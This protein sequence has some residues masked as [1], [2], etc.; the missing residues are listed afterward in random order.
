MYIKDIF[1]KNETVISLEVFPPKAQV[2]LEDVLPAVQTLAETKPAYMSVTYG[3]GGG[4]TANALEVAS[5][6]QNDFGV[7]ALAHLTCIGATRDAILEILDNFKARNIRNILALR[8]DFP[9]EVPFDKDSMEYKYAYQL[10][11]E[12][13]AYG[14]F[15]VGG[16]CYPEGHVENPNKEKDID[17]L[18]YKIEAG[19][20]FLVT[21]LF[22]DNNMLYSFLYRL[23]A[24]NINIPVTAGI[25]PVTSGNSIKRMC[26]MSGATLTPKFRAMVDKFGDKPDALRQAGIA[27]ATEQIIDLISNGV[28]RIHIYTMNKPEIAGKILENISS[29]IH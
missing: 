2:P 28:R 6:I 15:C 4:N 12:I 17:N 7:T 13:K 23:A 26:A 5:A 20:D 9:K 14:G 25:M 8:G 3:A 27:Y 19:V 21:Q 16:A 1:A 18:L 22:F 11:R 24:K 10:I 29:I